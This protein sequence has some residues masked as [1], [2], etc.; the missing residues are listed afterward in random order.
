MSKY[1]LNI[2]LANPVTGIDNTLDYTLIAVTDFVRDITNVAV[3]QSDTERTLIVDCNVIWGSLAVLATA[4]DQDCIAVRNNE[5]GEGELI[6]DKADQWG[7][8]NPE[9]FLTI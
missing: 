8:F 5:T 9:F 6:G 2:G 1:T 7:P 3:K 4:L